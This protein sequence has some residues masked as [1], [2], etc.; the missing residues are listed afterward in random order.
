MRHKREEVGPDGVAGHK[1]R[2]LFTHMQPNQTM[3][4]TQGD[5]MELVVRHI[6]PHRDGI[7]DPFD[8]PAEL[9]RAVRA[10]G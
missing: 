9:E 6:G 1:H 8:G 10:H 5:P 4:G 7:L 2:L 3:C